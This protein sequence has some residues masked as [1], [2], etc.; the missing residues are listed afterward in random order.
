MSAP[1]SPA[2]FAASVP[3]FYE[4]L[5]P[6]ERAVLPFL[7]DFWLRPD[8]RI[9]P[10]SW[11]SWGQLGGRGFGK[12]TA[13]AAFV[14]GEVAA[15]RATSIALMAPTDDRVEEVPIKFLIETAPPHMRP[16]RYQ[17]GLIWPNGVR[18]ESFTP[19][20]PGRPRSGNYS[21][22]WL[23]EIV[24][25]N[26]NT[27]LEAFK[28]ITTA[29]RVGRAQVVWDTT[30]KGVND[31][32]LA[33][34]AAHARDPIANRITRGTMLDNPALSEQYLREECAKYLGREFAE[35]VLGRTYTETAGAQ[36]QQAWLDRARVAPED[37]PALANTIAVIDPAQSTRADADETGLARVSLGRDGH[38]YF[39]DDESGRMSPEEWGD[40]AIAWCNEDASGVM[41]ERNKIGDLGVAV[42]R[43]RAQTAGLKVRLL[44]EAQRTFPA[45]TRGVVYV[46]EV[47]AAS[48]KFSRGS[49]PAVHT[50]ARRVHLVG[51][52]PKL[53]HELVTY[54][55]GTR[56]SP[57]RYDCYVYGVL[58]LAGLSRDTPGAPAVAE[59]TAL[60]NAVRAA[61][62]LGGARSDISV[63]AAM[64]RG[65]RRI[66]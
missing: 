11:R 3:G 16:E 13:I 15:G 9:T 42:I 62:A 24:D 22:T 49:G 36:F 19:E 58:E 8:Q 55:P 2:Q 39:R 43:A 35:E 6:R 18:A 20:A 50:E 25:W 7:S 12:S 31:V 1:I 41:I 4:S 64:A 53:E 33:L 32:I 45:R 27:R 37:M 30:S 29:C 14:N 5:T 66:D 34:L 48:S 26:P 60:A 61:T 40:Q 54:E 51:T 56:R 52:F 47:V 63:L 46:R 65:A 38:V 17:G 10:G 21:L 28:N 23:V 44:T 57:N 59:A